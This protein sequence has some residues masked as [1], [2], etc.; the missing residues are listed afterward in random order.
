MPQIAAQS[1]N[2]SDIKRHPSPYYYAD[3]FKN[4]CDEQKKVPVKISDTEN[5]P[6]IAFESKTNEKNSRA[7]SSHRKYRKSCSLDN[8]KLDKPIRAKS[9]HNRTKHKK[10]SSSV[11]TQSTDS[12]DAPHEAVMPPNRLTSPC[13]CLTPDDGLDSEMT[14][15][16]HVYETAFD[17]RISKSDDDLDELDKVSNHSL[18]LQTNLRENNPGPSADSNTPQNRRKVTLIFPKPSQSDNKSVANLSQKLQ[19][20]LDH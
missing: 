13:A 5:R 10:K 2:H 1:P 14:R 18:L 11:D 3:I 16:R 6:H 9:H 4:K 15:Q 7:K 8:P 19:V 17:C 20:S 12:R